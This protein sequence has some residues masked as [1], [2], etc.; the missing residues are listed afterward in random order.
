MSTLTIRPIRGKTG[1]HR[2]TAEFIGLLTS[3]Q[4]KA[5]CM[6]AY[7]WECDTTKGAREA[8]MRKAF[9]LSYPQS[10]NLSRIYE[11]ANKY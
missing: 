7:Y 10:R 11:A 8:K 4:D 6:E 1:R 5:K 9:G 2:L 3:Y